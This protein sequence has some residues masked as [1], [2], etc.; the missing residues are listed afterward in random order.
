[1]IQTFGNDA[2][3]TA[4]I[5]TISLMAHP[6]PAIVN[7]RFAPR[8]ALVYAALFLAVGWYLPLFP[9]WLSAQGLDASAIGFV[10]A[11]FQFT[12]IVGTP[13]GTRLSDRYGT[14]KGGI[15]ASALATVVALIVLGC[16]SGFA[17]IFAAT[18][19]YALTTSPIMPLID[20]YALKGLSQ[21]ALPYGP[22]RLWGSV[23]FIVATL[24]GGVLLGFVRRTD[25][26]WLI[27]V[28]G[29]LVAAATLALVPLARVEPV[30]A[31]TGARSHLRSPAF[32]AIVAAGCPIQAS[33]AVYYGFSTLDWSAKG[34]D[35]VTI[36]ILWALGVA[37]EIVLFALAPRLPASIGPVTLILI[38]AAGG[39]V[40]WI[41]TAFDP[42]LGLLAPLQMLHALSFGATHLGTMMFLSRNAP[43]GGRAAAQ[44]DVSTANGV[45]MAAASALSGLLYGAGGSYAYLAM[46]VLAAGGAGFALIAARL[47]SAPER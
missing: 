43:E 40:R 36:G 24:S 18:I 37:A 39:V 13:A 30:T 4:R 28:G 31:R 33:H 41:A 8:L 23:A 5:V 44:G 2:T 42:P 38:G 17:A 26:I 15:L 45:M 12:R 46:A 34:Y 9:V 47:M 3:N 20:A 21:R 35:G 11:A 32:L 22:V 6:A 1:M 19:L 27:F 16:V 29:C 14:P 7:D 10:L 25:L